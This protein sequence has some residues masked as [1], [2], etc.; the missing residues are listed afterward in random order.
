MPLCFKG[1][2]EWKETK[3]LTRLIAGCKELLRKV[4]K[5]RSKGKYSSKSSIIKINYNSFILIAFYRS[6]LPPF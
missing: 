1:V 5:Y 4:I 6:A 3:R 2:R